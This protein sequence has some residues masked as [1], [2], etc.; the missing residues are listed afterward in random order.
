MSYTEFGPRVRVEAG[1]ARKTAIATEELLSNAQTAARYHA[2]YQ[3]Q[4]VDERGVPL[5]DPATGAPVMEEV[6][7]GKDALGKPIVLGEPMTYLDDYAAPVWYVYVLREVPGG[8][9]KDGKPATV[10][11]WLP[12]GEPHPSQVDA[13]MAASRLAV[14]L[15]G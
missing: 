15:E 12:E 4:K 9:D 5:F 1:A 7:A 6:P 10:E 3:R 8:T 11:R 14:S 13:F 2:A